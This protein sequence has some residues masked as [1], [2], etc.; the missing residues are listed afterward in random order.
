MS[1]AKIYNGLKQRFEAVVPHYIAHLMVSLLIGLVTL[2]PIAGGMFYA[3]REWRDWEKSHGF[4]PGGF[5]WDD[6]LWP[7][8]P[9]LALD[10]ALKVWLY[11]MIFGGA[12]E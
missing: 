2:S 10:I 9:A 4:A 7:F 3:G 6:F 8:L 5:R 11:L 12:S 1:V